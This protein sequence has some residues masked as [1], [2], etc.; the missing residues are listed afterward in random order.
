MAKGDV[1]EGTV[2][3]L[4]DFS[5]HL[6]KYCQVS[7]DLFT[8]HKFHTNVLKTKEALKVGQEVLTLKF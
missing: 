6:L 5:V 7:M 8:Y 3:R 2:K 4:T 1:V